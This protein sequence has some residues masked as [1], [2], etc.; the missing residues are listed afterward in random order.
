MV[1]FQVPTEVK[2]MELNATDKEKRQLAYSTQFFDFTPDAFIDSITSPALDVMKEHLEAAK[3]RIA[4]EFVGK[5]NEKD[6]EQAFSVIKDTYTSHANDVFNKFGHYLKKNIFAIPSNIILPEDSPHLKPET[7]GYNGDKLESDLKDFEEKI[8]EV[9]NVKYRIAALKEKLANLEVVALRQQKRLQE[10]EK[11][12]AEKC[13][14]PMIDSQLDNL[15]EKLNRMKPVMLEEI[16]NNN[17]TNAFFNGL[18]ER[19]RKIEIDE[20]ILSKKM[21]VNQK[22]NEN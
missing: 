19:K 4:S 5:V 22:E 10:T 11:F 18:V 3:E 17:G 6:L 21:R 15:R 12:R 20:A 9:S 7:K 13:Q 2:N 14:L 8:Q 16:Q 1:K